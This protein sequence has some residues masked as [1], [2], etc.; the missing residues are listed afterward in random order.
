M[1]ATVEVGPV[2]PHHAYWKLWN[3]GIIPYGGGARA[4]RAN[5]TDLGTGEA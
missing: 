5:S 1:L 4:P 3:D 2:C